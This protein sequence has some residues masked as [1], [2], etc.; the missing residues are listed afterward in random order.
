MESRRRAD[1]PVDA[2]LS[3]A[4]FV[5]DVLYMVPQV[6]YLVVLVALFVLTLPFQ[7]AIAIWLFASS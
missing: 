4:Y 2:L 3:P 5:A 6:I 7:I 1:R